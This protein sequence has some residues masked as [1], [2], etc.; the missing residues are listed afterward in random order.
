MHRQCLTLLYNV[1]VDNGLTPLALIAAALRGARG[2]QEYFAHLVRSS[3][4][5]A[6]PAGAEHAYARLVDAALAEAQP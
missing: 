2:N 5:R 6:G 3:A 4:T 1:W